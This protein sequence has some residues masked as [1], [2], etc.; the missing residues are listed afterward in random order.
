[1]LVAVFH[2]N[3]W[4]QAPTQSRASVGIETDEAGSL[5]VSFLGPATL[6]R[7]TTAAA[8]ARAFHCDPNDFI[9]RG[10]PG[11]LRLDGVCSRQLARESESYHAE[12]NLAPI[13][14]LM[15]AAP[16]YGVDVRLFFPRAEQ[17]SVEPQLTT[18]AL[19]DGRIRASGHW[20]ATIGSREPRIA[21]AYGFS[22]RLPIPALLGLGLAGYA[23]I[24]GFS[25]WLGRWACRTADR[26]A[27]WFTYLCVAGYAKWLGVSLWVPAVL[28]ERL[29]E[30]LWAALSESG[31]GRSVL[32]PIVALMPM[33]LGDLAIS[34]ATLRVWRRL[35]GWPI[36]RSRTI[37]MSALRSAEVLFASMTVL[38]FAA[39]PGNLSLDTRLGG[40]LAGWFLWL[41]AD[42]LRRRFLGAKIRPLPDGELRARID[43]LSAKANIRF[44]RTSV[45]F[46]GPPAI[47]ADARVLWGPRVVYTEPLLRGL[48]RREVDAVTVME[49]GRAR[50][51]HVWVRIAASLPV[52]LGSG[53]LA[54][55]DDARYALA[56]FPGVML[57]Q[58]LTVSVLM[59]HLCLR[60]DRFSAR[61]A[62][63]PPDLVSALAR[64]AV[65]NQE[66]LDRPAWLNW[67]A[68]HPPMLVRFAAIA[69]VA[70]L[71][72]ADIAAAIAE[73]AIEPADRYSLDGPD[74][75]PEGSQPAPSAGPAGRSS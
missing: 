51:R 37:V 46:G 22:P 25:F 50:L 52:G 6:D 39:L 41:G 53:A 32:V 67:L 73:A 64:I 36:S 1:V 2:F 34:Q 68:R 15:R 48:S 20:T 27:G 72:H 74:A 35:R 61:I 44:K 31:P 56:A 10:D 13:D 28:L 18:R 59:R 55:L 5:R 4:A 33:F 57:L 66:P 14:A 21:L 16:D 7:Q 70:G 11:V 60:R 65:L 43:A 38:F 42:W 63:H 12:W 29:P 75:T 17:W 40:I 58:A 3:A 69:A 45:V 49:I 24:A 62:E 71:S 8:L 23:A 54:L 26:A 19:A 47:V 30:R 9:A